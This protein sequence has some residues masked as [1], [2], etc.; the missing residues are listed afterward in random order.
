MGVAA[1]VREAGAPEGGEERSGQ[2]RVGETTV[3]VVLLL[4]H[5]G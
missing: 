3:M 5:Q 1:D 4:A 2:D